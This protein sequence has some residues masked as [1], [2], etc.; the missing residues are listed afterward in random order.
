[1]TTWNY[2][3]RPLFYFQTISPPTQV[4]CTLLKEMADVSL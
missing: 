3:Y 4:L 1:M 2:E